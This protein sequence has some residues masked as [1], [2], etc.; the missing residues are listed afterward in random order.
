M[1]TSSNPDAKILRVPFSEEGK[2]FFESIPA[3]GADFTGRRSDD[4]DE[5]G[6]YFHIPG[7]TW[8]IRMMKQ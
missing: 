2:K 8:D 5:Y 3:D 6:I 4:T 1:L 7:E